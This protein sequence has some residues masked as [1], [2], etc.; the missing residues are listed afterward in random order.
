MSTICM[1][2]LMYGKHYLA[3]L[4]KKCVEEGSRIITDC[5]TQEDLDLIADAVITSGLKVIAVDPGSI[6]RNAIQKTDHSE[7][8]KAEDQDPCSGRKR[9][10]QYHSPDG[11]TVAFTENT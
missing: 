5:I 8:E 3:D 10:C 2:D 6:Y 11:R 4:M 1:K 9:E 7:Q